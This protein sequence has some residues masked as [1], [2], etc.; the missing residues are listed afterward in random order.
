MRKNN[1]ELNNKLNLQTYLNE[2]YHDSDRLIIQIQ[3][4]IDKIANSTSLNGVSI[5]EKADYAKAI[6]ALI[7]SK[8][9]AL[10]IKLDINKLATEVLKFGGDENGALNALNKNKAINTK[11]INIKELQ[12][13]LI[14]KK[15]DDN[16]SEKEQVVYKI[17]KNT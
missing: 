13:A 10:K 17:N 9:N 4:E 2:L 16:I 15:S 8:S 11:A 3:G 1:I 5:E 12:N 6:N 14:N 7:T